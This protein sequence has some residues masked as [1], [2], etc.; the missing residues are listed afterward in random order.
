MSNLNEITI[1]WPYFYHIT[2]RV[3]GVRGNFSGKELYALFKMIIA[4]MYKLL[5][6][7]QLIFHKD[8]G[9]GKSLLF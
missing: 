6:K 4:D 1:L 5:K 3:G 2:Y 7:P 8:V 9:L